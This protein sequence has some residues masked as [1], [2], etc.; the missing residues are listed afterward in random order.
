MQYVRWQKKKSVYEYEDKFLVTN[1]Y[2]FC[3]LYWKDRRKRF[4]IKMTTYSE[5]S[6]RAAVELKASENTCCQSVNTQLSS[7]TSQFSYA[8][9]RKKSTVGMYEQYVILRVTYFHKSVE[10]P[11]QDD[12]N[13]INFSGC[14]GFYTYFSGDLVSSSGV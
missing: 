5:S 10:C 2:A 7:L 3:I 13:M 12:M 8:Q 11:I 9:K 14:I 1:D 6:G 4:K